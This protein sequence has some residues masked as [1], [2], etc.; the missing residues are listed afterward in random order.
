[1]QTAGVVAIDRAVAGVP[2]IF[3]EI[4]RVLFQVVFNGKKL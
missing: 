2:R 3:E 1:M 4:Q